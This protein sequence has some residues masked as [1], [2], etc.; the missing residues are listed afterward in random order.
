M[1]ELFEKFGEIKF[2][3]E[4][5]LCISDF[6]NSFRKHFSLSEKRPHG[7]YKFGEIVSTFSSDFGKAL[8][9]YFK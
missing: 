9:K 2:A 8:E 7:K 4:N 3:E 1:I 6:E 5:S